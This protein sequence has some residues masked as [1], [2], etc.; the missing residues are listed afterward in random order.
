MSNFFKSAAMSLLSKTLQTLLSKYLSDVDVEGVN[1]PSL[2]YN[3]DDG[4]GVRLSNVKLRDGAKLMDLPGKRPKKDKK[5]R[6]DKTKSSSTTRK[7]RQGRKK[8]RRKKQQEDE[9]SE[10]SSERPGGDTQGD[11]E[12]NNNISDDSPPSHGSP[13]SQA[14][15]DNAESK[16]SDTR[17]TQQ[18]TPESDTETIGSSQPQPPPP[19]SSSS[20]FFWRSSSSRV[21]EMPSSSHPHPSTETQNENQEPDSIPEDNQYG[22]SKSAS[23]LSLASDNQQENKVSHASSRHDSDWEEPKEGEREVIDEYE[24]DEEKEVDDDSTIDEEEDDLPMILRLGNDG[25]IGTLDVRLVGRTIHVYVE[26]A[27]LT[28][29]AVR[30]AS[31]ATEDKGEA[32]PGTQDRKKSVKT[33]P[34]PQT[35]GD[36]VLN[37]NGLAR[38]LSAIPNLFLRDIRVL[39]VIR[40][41]I[42]DQPSQEE[43]ASS[44]CSIDDAIVDLSVEFLSVT[45]GDD[46]LANYREGAEGEGDETESNFQKGSEDPMYEDVM[47]PVYDQNEYLF[48]RI[49]T[50][51]GPEGGILLRIYPPGKATGDMAS[52]QRPLWSRYTWESMT[53]YCFLRCSGL[54]LFSRIYL[55]TK[56]EVASGDVWFSEDNEN[57]DVDAMLFGVDYIAPGPQ[58][59]LPPIGRS[60]SILSSEDKY[61]VHEGAMVYQEDDNGIQSSSIKSSFHRVAR[62]MIPS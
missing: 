39:F 53:Q 3:S 33:K 27:S 56:E 7:R 2:L 47:E 40:D 20:W 43:T 61:W 60:D 49:R 36:R 10:T 41:E 9:D 8:T 32:A 48:K 29:E 16:E 24:E 55:G 23:S 38:A 21:T 54:D 14:G 52:K 37:E 46:F 34:D 30:L 50:G 26:D 18:S 13:T 1:L 42:Y 57:Y 51:R 44:R 31:T 19:S 45:D 4:W 12:T 25:R 59:P 62:N 28:V 15:S 22:G 58:P 35:V 17:T 6:N 5:V 11:K